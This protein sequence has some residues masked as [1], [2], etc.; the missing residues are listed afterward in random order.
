[1][2]HLI[3]C[4]GVAYTADVSL[5]RCQVA[6]CSTDLCHPIHYRGTASST[7]L[8]HPIH[9]RGAASS[10]DLCHPI[11]YR[12][13][14]CSTDLCHPI[15]YRGTASSTDCVIQFTIEVQPVVQIVSSNSL[16][17]YSL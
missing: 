6:A 7:D 3:H 13:T 2:C 15:H 1:M 17:R 11:H 16:S 14:A 8:C 9:D 5:N 10:T 12:G 4:Q